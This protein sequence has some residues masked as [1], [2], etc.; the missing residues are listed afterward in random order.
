MED[1]SE[2]VELPQGRV[3]YRDVGSGPPLLF[4]HG[5]L[6]NGLL[7][8]EVVPRLRDDFR[9]IVPDLPLGAH[10]TPMD[11]D[12]DLGAHG[13][14]DLLAELVD[15]LPVDEPAVVGNDTGGA[16]CQLLVA[17]HPEAVGALVLTDCDAFDRFPPPRYRY[18]SWGARLPGFVPAMSQLMRSHAVLRSR[19]A[20]GSLTRTG[21]PDDLLDAFH[22]PL[23]QDPGVRRDTRKVLADMRPAHTREAA[24]A[25]PDFRKP[26]LLA[27]SPDDPV[28][29]ME[30]ARRLAGLFPEAELETVPGAWCFVPQD[31]PD[32]LA[33]A[34]RGWAEDAAP[35]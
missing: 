34:I 27:W 15:A 6:V 11:P 20:Y 35:W 30:D 25:F 24:E 7:W 4:V 10:R 13:V 21:L 1:P 29:P 31:N 17:R 5:I 12:A 32:G 22:E 18:L 26:V 3:R 33:D 16:F 2:A 28:F 19:L 23:A 8:R 9:C 14:A